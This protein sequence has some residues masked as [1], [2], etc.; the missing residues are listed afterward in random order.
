[1]YCKG[2]KIL[3][4]GTIFLLFIFRYWGLMALDPGQSIDQYV[5]D[6]WKNKE[7]L[8]GNIIYSIAQTPDGYLWLSTANGVMRFDGVKFSPMEFNKKEDVG[9]R[10]KTIYYILF[11]DREGNLWLGGS[12]ELIKY[13]HQIGK[14]TSFTK[15]MV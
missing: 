3:L 15:K 11:V 10:K 2:K 5:S 4:A 9:S 1:M 7:G 12:R 8:A 14:F 6:Q 13:Q